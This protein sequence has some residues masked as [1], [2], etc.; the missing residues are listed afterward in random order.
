MKTIHNE[1]GKLYIKD[2]TEGIKQ[3]LDYK[4]TNELKLKVSR[5][6]DRIPN[7]QILFISYNI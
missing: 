2:A 6:T 5:I 4:I 1:I 7:L 3:Q